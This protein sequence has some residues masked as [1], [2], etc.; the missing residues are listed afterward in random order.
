MNLQTKYKLLKAT[1]KVI[2]ALSI[3]WG[4]LSAFALEMDVSPS[5]WS[6]YVPR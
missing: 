4:T 2:G 3:P 1:T 6:P 5:V